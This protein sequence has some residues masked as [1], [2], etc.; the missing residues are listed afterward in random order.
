MTREQKRRLLSVHC[1]KCWMGEGVP[2]VDMR[3]PEGPG[4]P[5]R[6][7]HRERYRELKEQESK[8]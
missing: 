2:C 5:L 4:R 3:K 6:T 8:R 1:P 7:F